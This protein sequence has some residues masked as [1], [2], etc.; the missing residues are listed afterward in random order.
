MSCSNCQ[1]EK[2]RRRVVEWSEKARRAVEL[3]AQGL[4]ISKIAIAIGTSHST[5]CRL[6]KEGQK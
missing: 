4:T 1:C 3:R 6:L 2:C 5:V